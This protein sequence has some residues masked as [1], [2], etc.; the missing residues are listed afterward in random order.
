M[1][2]NLLPIGSIVLLKGAKRKLMITGRI[3]SDEKNVDIY[4]YVGCIYPEGMT[5]GD[6]LFFFNRDAL[7]RVYFIGFQDEEELSFKTEVLS[8]LKELTIKDGQIVSKEV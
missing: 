6:S 1:Y 8:Q 4:D 5:G 7:E 3:V 2:E